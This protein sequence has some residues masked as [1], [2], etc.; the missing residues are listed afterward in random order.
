MSFGARLDVLRSRL[1]EYRSSAVGV[2]FLQELDRVAVAQVGRDRGVM[3]GLLGDLG[4]ARF[5]HQDPA[6][7]MELQAGEFPVVSA[8]VG[9]FEEYRAAFVQLAEDPESEVDVGDEVGVE[10]AQPLLRLVDPDF[11]RDAAQD[12]CTRDREGRSWD[13][14]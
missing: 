12:I 2:V 10:R 8:D 6:G 11:A 7:H 1:K 14:V 9:L 5:H 13:S 3:A 4:A